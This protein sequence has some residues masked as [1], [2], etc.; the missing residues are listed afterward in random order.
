MIQK[1]DDAEF[2]QNALDMWLTC[3]KSLKGLSPA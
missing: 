1:K 2:R 3:S